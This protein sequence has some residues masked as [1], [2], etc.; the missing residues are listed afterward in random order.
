[1]RILL[2]GSVVRSCHQGGAVWAVLQWAL[3]LRSL[4]HDVTLVEQLP[5]PATAEQRRYAA[6]IECQTGVRPVLL[7][8]EGELSPSDLGR[9]DLVVNLSGVLRDPALLAAASRRLYVDLDP[10]FTQV[11]HAQGADV[12]LAG[13]D[14]YA[15]VGL[16]VGRPGCRVPTLDRHWWPVLPPVALDR[17]RP[18]AGVTRWAA[19]TVGHWRSYGTLTHDGVR[20]G[21]R[22]HSVRRLWD[23]PGRSPLPLQLALGISPEETKDLAALDEHGW[24]RLDPQQVA[25][26]PQDYRA[27]VRGSAAELSI[28]KS[29]Y[30]SSRSGWFSDRSACYLAA[31][32]PVVAQDTGWSAVL[33]SGAGLLAYS[34]VDSAGAALE[35]VAAGH[36]RHSRAAH[37][38]AREHLDARLVLGRLLEQV[39]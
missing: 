8:G 6:L 25:A 10:G 20:Y 23:L 13:H 34:D 19:T 7:G 18:G 28:A 22:A 16:A 30:V 27:F 29:G 5:G 2:A 39:R 14:A 32:R 24:Q 35:Q 38:W 9:V 4:G 15:T 26:S 1:M 3:G 33:P 21:Q 37:E 17:W 11:W 36:A 12:G 31:G